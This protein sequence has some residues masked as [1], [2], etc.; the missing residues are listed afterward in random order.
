MHVRVRVR[1]L[2]RVRVRVSGRYECTPGRYG[3]G[4]MEDDPQC[5]GPCESGFFCPWNSTSPMQARAVL[6]G[7]TF[8][9]PVP[10]RQHALSRLPCVV[11]IRCP[12]GVQTGTVPSEVASQPTFPSYVPHVPASL[13]WH[14]ARVFQHVTTLSLLPSPPHLPCHAMNVCPNV[15]LSCMVHE[16]GYYTKP[17]RPAHQRAEQ[18]ICEP[19][20]YC[21]AGIM[22][23]CPAT[24]YGNAS[25]LA[26]PACT[27]PCPIGACFHAM[28]LVLLAVLCTFVFVP[29]RLF[30]FPYI[31]CHCV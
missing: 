19:G 31:V 21:M 10:C 27:A 23:D 26:T 28:P 6:C 5:T 3:S 29:V 16:Q 17:N 14:T 18:V 24:T 7:Q 2:V 9:A 13:Q 15:E 25:G 8:D 22:T 12:A 4:P 11:L 30:T 1:V 20:R